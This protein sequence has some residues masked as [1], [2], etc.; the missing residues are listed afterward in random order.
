MQQQDTTEYQYVISFV[1]LTFL[2]LSFC[3]LFFSSRHLYHILV[4][5]SCDCILVNRL[6]VWWWWIVAMYWHE[7]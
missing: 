2:S 5:V 1:M 6:Q 3:Y 7:I 4:F